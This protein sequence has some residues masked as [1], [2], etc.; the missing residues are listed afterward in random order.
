[1][2]SWFKKKTRNSYKKCICKIIF[3]PLM[4]PFPPPKKKKKQEEE[5]H[6][7]IVLFPIFFSYLIFVQGNRDR[8]MNEKLIFFLL[9]KNSSYSIIRV[10]STV[11]S[12]F[13]FVRKFAICFA[14][15]SLNVIVWRILSC[16]PLNFPYLRVVFPN[17]VF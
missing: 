3:Y 12:W 10:Y 6:L 14:T 11:L 15:K 13:F 4:R 2:R 7:P 17:H 16:L 5:N 8:T 1:M 9:Q